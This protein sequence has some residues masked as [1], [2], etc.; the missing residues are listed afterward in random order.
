MLVAGAGCGERS[1]PTGP[2]AR[3]YP[4]TVQTAAERSLVVAGPAQRIAVLDRATGEI[5]GEL[6]AASHIVG[7]PLTATGDIRFPV[8]RRLRPDLIVASQGMNERDL[9]RAGRITGAKVYTAPA[10]SIR[11]VERTITQL[12]LLTGKPVQARALIRRIEERRHSIA[13]KLAGARTISVFVD[14]GFFTTVSDQSLIGDLIREAHGRN[15][16]GNQAQAG[17]V[18]LR[19]L[20]QRDPDVYLATSDTQITLADLQKNRLARKLR[21]VREGRFTIANA[22]LLQPGPRIG[23]GLAEIAH[24]LHPNAFR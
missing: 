17:P 6:G 1:E 14:T 8:L 10:D 16:F 13:A 3:L 2:D 18:D 4:V 20:L 9:S 21:A 19:D 22:D 11:Q 12:G 23:D 15:V 7:T 5:I 24:L